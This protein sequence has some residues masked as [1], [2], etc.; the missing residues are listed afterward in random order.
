M[1]AARKKRAKGKRPRRRAKKNPCCTNPGAPANPLKNPAPRFSALPLFGDGIAVLYR[2]RSD[3]HAYK[4]GL[5]K[6]VVRYDPARR[7]VVI[8]PVDAQFI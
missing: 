1:M 7:A 4:H 5:R 2:R 8:Y 6:A 3:G